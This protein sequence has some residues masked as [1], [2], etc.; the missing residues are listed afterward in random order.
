MRTI[1]W[2]SGGI[3]VALGVVSMAV[4]GFEQPGG[5]VATNFSSYGYDALPDLTITSA[6]YSGFLMVL[7]G[8]VLMVRAN[9]TA[10]KQTGGY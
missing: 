10:W 8:A 7:L 9:S 1:L 6:G 3:S 5:D 2:L 4:Y